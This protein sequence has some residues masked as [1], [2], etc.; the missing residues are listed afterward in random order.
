M[1]G[2]NKIYHPPFFSRVCC[3]VRQKKSSFFLFFSA[4]RPHDIFGVLTLQMHQFIV[5]LP[6]MCSVRVS[7]KIFDLKVSRY[8]FQARYNSHKFVRA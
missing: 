2:D 4:L 8:R 5:I 1:R 3:A 6:A 7:V